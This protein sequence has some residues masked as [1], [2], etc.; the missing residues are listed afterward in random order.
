MNERTRKIIDNHNEGKYL[1]DMLFVA[2]YIR[3]LKEK[4]QDDEKLREVSIALAEIAMYVNSLHMDRN[5]FHLVLNQK[6]EQVQELRKQL[7]DK[8]IK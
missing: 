8:I 2:E 4:N 5:S 7:N 6:F 3:D 1:S